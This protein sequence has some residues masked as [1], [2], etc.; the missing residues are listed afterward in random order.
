M[1]L[2]EVEKI[3]RGR[4]RDT[5]VLLAA[6]FHK[7]ELGDDRIVGVKSIST[8]ASDYWTFPFLTTSVTFFWG[9]DKDDKLV[10]VWVWKTVDAP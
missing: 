9:F 1:K 3:A 5:A 4:G 10:D 8:E 6:G 7:Q 2:S